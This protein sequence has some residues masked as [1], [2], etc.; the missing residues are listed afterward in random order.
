MKHV[1]PQFALDIPKDSTRAP[2][3]LEAE[4]TE[5]HG[6][7][8]ADQ[9]DPGDL[10]KLPPAQTQAEWLARLSPNL[11]AQVQRQRKGPVGYSEIDPVTGMPF[12]ATG[13][14]VSA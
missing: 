3:R 12:A 13:K 11:R 7:P 8:Q 4:E 14:G 1:A 9:P 5:C 6:A 2:L 10:L